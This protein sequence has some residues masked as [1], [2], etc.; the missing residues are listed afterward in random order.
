[1][2]EKTRD[3]YGIIILIIT[4]CFSSLP[5]LGGVSAADAPTFSID[6]RFE[7]EQETIPGDWNIT[8]TYTQLYTFDWGEKFSSRL[9]VNLTF[10][11]E[12][13][14]V[15][16]SLDVDEKEVI[17]SIQLDI[18]SLVWDLSILAEDTI[19]YSNQ[20]N[21]P[22]KDVVEFSVEL[23]LVPMHK[24]P[25]ITATAEQILDQQDN[26]EDKVENKFEVSTDY[27]F[28]DFFGVDASWKEET[29]DDRL[30]DNSDLRSHDWDFGFEYSQAYTPTFKVDFQTDWQGTKEDTLNN[31]GAIL[32]TDRTKVLENKLKFTL[33]YS[34]NMLSEIEISQTDDFVL[35]ED[36]DE[37]RFLVE[38][39]QPLVQLG[40]LTESLE[41]TQ[42]KTVNPGVDTEDNNIEFF[43]ELFG[44]PYIYTDY[45]IKYTYTRNDLAD[46]ISPL[47]DKK[48]TDHEFDL[49]VTLTPN[50]HITLDNSFNW[51]AA[52]EDG[53]KTGNSKDL[54]IEASF[55][56][57]L[58]DFPNL[59]FEPSIQITTENNIATGEKQNSQQADLDFIYSVS[60]PENITWEINPVY[61]ISHD[62]TSTEKSIDFSNDLTV[63]FILPTWEV[64][65]E[66]SSSFDN[67]F[68]DSEG[69]FWDHEFLISANRDLTPN[70]E[71]EVE[72]E[73]KV[74]GDGQNTDKLESHLGWTY[75]T[76]SLEFEY[77]NDRIMEGPRDINRT[78]SVE[79]QMEF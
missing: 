40:T 75:G 24:L 11:M 65:F 55:E 10:E 37:I 3:K 34:P 53:S 23:N 58:M 76:T 22:R 31:A 62:D 59:T 1:M 50:D 42:N 2:R 66:E 20:F 7:R 26:L 52:Y 69:I 56:G 68:G 73:Y 9:D 48:T 28:G 16:R 71:F 63:D 79:L 54:K 41:I 45:S 19:T 12:M 5:L 13:E 29:T 72:Y 64:S 49:S 78:Y 61:S 60:L 57:E 17:P 33:D 36:D 27:Q 67:T 38:A 30:F 43:V 14:D 70:I 51:S 6:H 18:G 15:I 4:L 21:F 44:T 74:E 47:S 77:I 35:G 32:L 25:A 46:A 39:N 8:D